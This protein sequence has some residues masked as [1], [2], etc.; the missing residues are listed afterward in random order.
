MFQYTTSLI[1]PASGKMLKMSFN[2]LISLTMK[3]TTVGC[4]VHKFF[5]NLYKHENGANKRKIFCF[6]SK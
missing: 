6:L 2:N 1:T 3:A 5:M 4:V